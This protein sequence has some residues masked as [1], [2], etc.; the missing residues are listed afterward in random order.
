[1]TAAIAVSR[2]AI[3][4]ERVARDL[5][6]RDDDGDDKD[7]DLAKRDDARR[8]KVKPGDAL[9]V[10]DRLQDGSKRRHRVRFVLQFRLHA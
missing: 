6:P 5:A 9:L 2:T 7:A 10:I 8:L 1:M 4:W 3:D